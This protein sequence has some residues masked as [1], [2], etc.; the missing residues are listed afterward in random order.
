MKTLKLH[1]Y[2]SKFLLS[3]R[4][5]VLP[6]YFPTVLQSYRLIFLISLSLL[7]TSL[8]AQ[9][10]ANIWYFGKHCGLDFNSGTP[11]ALHDGKTEAVWEGNSTICDSS[12]NL[13]FYTTI[14]HVYN[15]HHHIIATGLGAPSIG[16]MAIVKWPGRDSM[17][18]IFSP[19]Y[20]PD[21]SFS[22]SIL[23]LRQNNGE[24]AITEQHV[25]VE[26][27][28]DASGRVA[29]VRQANSDN[30]WVITRKFIDD[31]MIAF[32]VDE[33][34]FNPDPVSCVLPDE[35]GS[36]AGNWG[37]IKISYDKKYIVS[38]YQI[39]YVGDFEF[40]RFS[41]STGIIEYMY[42]LETIDGHIS[43][44]GIEFSPD[45]K[46]MYLIFGSG[47]N[48]TEVYQYDMNLIE[49]PDLFSNSGILVG[50]GVAWNMQLARDGMI[51][52]GN[53]FDYPY[54]YLNVISKPW[55]KGPGCSFEMSNVNTYPGDV[56]Q[57]LNNILVDYLLRFEWTGETCQGYPIQFKPN[58]IPTPQTI[59]WDFDDGTGSTSWQLS[60]TYSFKNP[61]VHE[62]K[63]DVWY[64]SGRYE[65]TSREIEISPSPLPLLGNDTLICQGASITLNANCDADFFS[66]STGQFGVSSITV[67]DS[68]TYWVRGRFNDSGCEG[69]DT[70]HIGFHQPTIIDETYL[71]ITPTTCNGTSGS[72]TGLTALGPT[73][74][75]Y[76]WKDL[77]E[78][79]V[80]TDIDVSGLPAGQYYLTITDSNSCETVSE[81]YTIE[82]A[83]NLQVLDVELTQPHCGR[84]DGEIVI[85]AFSPSGSGLEYSINDGADYSLDSIFT[86]LLAGTYV[87]RIRDI[88]NCEGFYID[89]P[90]SVADI[91]GPQVTDVNVTDETDFLG[92]WGD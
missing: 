51:Y 37:W 75:A 43:P 23:D 88:N 83:G 38:T 52:F 10:E 21:D 6:S 16:G 68:G 59:Q 55:I 45:S 65:H 90:I 42:T 89:N 46:F 70:I 18:Y 80:G 35:E 67:S 50:T 36:D 84:P 22:Y 19:G 31:A 32:L 12:G 66:W 86:D 60:P 3:Y 11:V 81:V 25:L 77:S 63:V 62:V 61:G 73:P 57:G 56:H 87:V 4:P 76:R 92:E 17:Y 41:A 44:R 49:N 13:L 85:H 39:G 40:C 54:Y 78:V 72:I 28:L 48:D 14:S 2:F 24:G 58:F 79:E 8:F 47:G 82:D 34:G 29:T 33:N 69:Y 5:T 9:N 15:K 26:A 1:L 30:I 7:S 53:N 71:Q 74:Y 64:P 20:A 91:P 27:A